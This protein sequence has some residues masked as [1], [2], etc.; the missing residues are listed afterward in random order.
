[1]GR[2][3]QNNFMQI[4]TGLLTLIAIGT[5]VLFICVPRLMRAKMWAIGAAYMAARSTAL[6]QMDKAHKTNIKSVHLCSDFN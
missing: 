4:I 5:I 2:C 6:V 3:R 1:M